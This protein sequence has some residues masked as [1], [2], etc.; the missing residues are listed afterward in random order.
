MSGDNIEL[1]ESDSGANNEILH[2]PESPIRLNIEAWTPTP[3]SQIPLM[4]PFDSSRD[5]LPT[6]IL[7]GFTPRQ[8]DVTQQRLSRPADL[9]VAEEPAQMFQRLLQEAQLRRTQRTGN[10]LTD[11]QLDHA[12]K[13][14]EDAGLGN[15]FG[16]DRNSFQ[17]IK[18]L[19]Q[20]YSKEQLEQ[21]KQRFQNKNGT[22]LESALERMFGGSQLVELRELLK[23]NYD[24]VTVIM[25]ALTELNQWV[26]GRSNYQ[27]KKVI[28]DTFARLTE[29]E[30]N[31][32][33]E[34]F[35]ERNNGKSLFDAI[36]EQFKND[37]TNT[38]LMEILFK[39]VDNYSKERMFDYALLAIR[40]GDIEMFKEAFRNTRAEDRAEFARLHEGK[41]NI[42]TFGS[43]FNPVEALNNLE[44]A[45][46]VLKNGEV[47]VATEILTFRGLFASTQ[48]GVDAAIDK[49]TPAQKRAYLAG[50]QFERLSP[51][52]L[53]RLTGADR[54]N[55]LYY[56]EINDEM[57]RVTLTYTDWKIARWE[58]RIRH[59]AE[60]S[61]VT[62][63]LDHGGVFANSFNDTIIS[64]TIDNMSLEDFNRARDPRTG[65]EFREQIERALRIIGKSDASIEQILKSYD[66]K[67]GLQSIEP[68]TVNQS[69]THG[70][71]RS[72]DTL[73]TIRQKQGYVDSDQAGILEAILNM[74]Q[75]EQARF[76]Q[77]EPPSEFR[78]KLLDLVNS[79]W[80]L[81]SPERQT[82][83]RI[84]DRLDKTGKL[85]ADII[86]RLTILN[87]KGAS[88]KDMVAALD[89][90]FQDGSL[91]RELQNNPAL[92]NQ[93]R[94]TILLAFRRGEIDNT[95]L[96]LSYLETGK[97]DLKTRLSLYDNFFWSHDDVAGLADLIK[98]S[99][100]E[101]RLELIRNSKEL[102]PFLTEDQRKLIVKIAAQ[103]GEIKPE[104]RLRIAI[105]TGRADVVRQIAESMRPEERIAARRVYENTF[106]TPL[107][108][109]LIRIGKFDAQMASRLFEAPRSTEQRFIDV[110]DEFSRTLGGFS[111]WFV[112]Q[113]DASGPQAYN[114]MNE[115][116]TALRRA[117]LLNTDL[118][119]EEQ[120]RLFDGVRN[121]L[122]NWRQSRNAGAE[123]VADLIIM[124]A[125][126]ILSL[127]SGGTSLAALAAT[128][129]GRAILKTLLRNAAT[130]LATEAALAAAL[131]PGFKELIMQEDYDLFSTEGGADA[132]IGALSLLLMKVGPQHLAR[133]TGVP[134][135]GTILQRQFLNTTTGAL[136][137]GFDGLARGVLQWDKSLSPEEN[138]Q[139]IFQQTAAATL[140]GGVFTTA[141]TAPGSLY[142]AFRSR[143]SLR[144]TDLVVRGVPDAPRPDDIILRQ[145]SKET[146]LRRGFQL[147]NQNGDELLFLHPES[148]ARITLNKDRIVKIVDPHENIVQIK[149]NPQGRPY[150]IEY[151][152]GIKLYN[153]SADPQRFQPQFTGWPFRLSDRTLRPIAPNHVRLYKNLFRQEEQRALLGRRLLSDIEEL[154]AAAINPHDLNLSD[155]DKL[156]LARE[157]INVFYLNPP[158]NF[159]GRLVYVDVPRNVFQQWRDDL[160]SQ[161]M[162]LN[163]FKIP[164]KYLRTA[165]EHALSDENLFQ[166][167][168]LW[169][170]TLKRVGASGQLES[171]DDF[172][173]IPSIRIDAKGKL[174]LQGVDNSIFQPETIVKL[175]KLQVIRSGASPEYAAL[176]KNGI[177]NLPPRLR[178]FLDKNGVTFRVIS[179]TEDYFT[180]EILRQRGRGWLHHTDRTDSTAFYNTRLNEIVFVEKN[181]FVNRLNHAFTH[182]IGHAIENLIIYQGFI[183]SNTRAAQRAYAADLL[184]LYKRKNILRNLDPDLSNRLES[185]EFDYFL[186]GHTKK[187]IPRKGTQEKYLHARSE[188]FAEIISKILRRQGTLDLPSSIEQ[189]F[190][191]SSVYIKQILKDVLEGNQTID[192]KNFTNRISLVRTVDFTVQAPNPVVTVKGNLNNA[193]NHVQSHTG[194]YKTELKIP[195]ADE[196]TRYRALYGSLDEAHVESLFRRLDIPVEQV[197]DLAEARG[198]LH[199]RVVDNQNKL[200]AAE[201][202]LREAGRFPPKLDSK[203]HLDLEALRVEYRQSQA[204]LAQ[205]ASQFNYLKRRAESQLLTAFEEWSKDRGG[206]SPLH[207]HI[208]KG[209]NDKNIPIN[210]GGWYRFGTGKIAI[211][212]NYLKA[213]FGQDLRLA[214]LSLHEHVHMEQ[215][216]LIVR[217]SLKAARQAL[218]VR[219][220]DE[221]ISVDPD[222]F[223]DK[224]TSIYSNLT[225]AKI[226]RDWLLHVLRH[227]NKLGELTTDLEA[228]ALRLVKE[229][230]TYRTLHEKF[231]DWMNS[232]RTIDNRLGHLRISK[233]YQY[234]INELLRALEHG[235]GDITAATLAKRLF[236]DELVPPEL[237]TAVKRFNEISENTIYNIVNDPGVPYERLK[238]ILVERFQARLA[239]LNESIKDSWEGYTRHY[240]ELEATGLEHQVNL[241][242]DRKA[243]EEIDRLLGRI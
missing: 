137:G 10:L 106:G 76:L 193:P 158:T 211:N 228:H 216:A 238:E 23:G 182:E 187:I 38:A 148:T 109:D 140:T 101:E 162:A 35:K 122:E 26:T 242:R 91:F 42:L 112:N 84:L 168:S 83:M 176:I 213:G 60:G 192:P 63:I 113:Y 151:S 88:V 92:A 199:A 154:R 153:R 240:I 165:R 108:A 191:N 80:S 172:F 19:F 29:R 98:N 78:V 87:A 32:L 133:I 50:K 89:K 175:N 30:I 223:I 135:N 152:S 41:L 138:F 74:S 132:A 82:A 96:G 31:D 115:L 147:I 102:L 145:V 24:N 44:I 212:E 156:I 34:K 190:P 224:V 39:G 118:S 65:R 170:G 61:L 234:S 110:Q 123:V 208:L 27:L 12:L 57:R 219:N 64:N 21:L 36:R 239:K 1:P 131:R 127:P 94:A 59:G 186:T 93:L 43:I 184:N 218:R 183:A 53:S 20:E 85:E 126:I 179:H 236:G 28:R 180:P 120:K 11:A 99:T 185:G 166:N 205:K 134:H 200:R 198:M 177:E 66:A 97:L 68:W 107:L 139:R 141:L 229:N 149:Y 124:A 90:A 197:G 181:L 221:F 146:L 25:T 48:R 111:E 8:A 217:H 243:Q 73:E 144:S 13:G 241:F 226:E 173:Q 9:P 79:F 174:I 232:A 163:E 67:I 71:S 15:P 130:R 231:D 75:A 215:D 45:R 220:G 69:L 116:V 189:L 114:R 196:L 201:Q 103:D 51:E 195:S 227:D 86:D 214:K 117:N 119:E 237:L 233:D 14:L 125:A 202:K 2:T 3:T 6:L 72:R 171:V 143:P 128:S 207:I 70:D 22:S 58:D 225:G 47:S 81:S 100:A 17:I 159:R 105:L 121:V 178:E 37:P 203:E 40:S 56:K 155:A 104:D 136:T 204:L 209:V 160:L 157:K 230:Q 235:S 62:R 54:E 222:V 49:M 5:H 194:V 161:N 7:T 188:V 206:I 33:N 16:G 18:R 169:Q 129:V 4:T 95:N 164:V 55:W 52:E 46:D 77:R 167:P 150:S 210:Y 142:R